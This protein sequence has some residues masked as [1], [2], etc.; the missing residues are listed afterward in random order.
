MSQEQTTL[1]DTI[2]TA[3][4]SVIPGEGVDATA[5]ADIT[6]PKTDA[7]EIKAEAPKSEAPREDRQR[8]PDGTFAPKE[9]APPQVKSAK[10]ETPPPP[11]VGAAPKR[12]TTWKKEQWENFD[13]LHAENP[14]LASY[15]LERE[16]Q[17]A[18]GVS[19]YK[20]EW[21]RAKPILDALTPFMPDLERHQIAPDRFVANLAQAHR[22]LALGSPQ[23]K[24]AMFAN[25]A[26]QYQIPL[27]QMFEQ[28]ADGQV[29]LRSIPTPQ[30]QG[31]TP[32]D[33]EQMVQK[34]F[35]EQSTTH[36][37]TSFQAARDA[38]GNPLYPHFEQVKETM[39]G[40][41]QAGLAEDLKGAYEAALRHPRHEELFSGVQRQ[42]RE[43]E[44]ARI[45]QEKAQQ[46]A[47][48]KRNAIST[49][50]ST[51]TGTAVANTGKKGLRAMLEENFDAVSA[52]RV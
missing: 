15:I 33:V 37:I 16:D 22:T 35:A 12:P 41:L 3:Y 14:T 2:E 50:T 28:G 42:Q 8:N 44:E 13:K 32:Q 20:S 27:N 25:L 38:S 46:A 39:A 31:L 9:A 34:K 7:V 43:A 23:E 19:T 26:Q 4:N 47:R 40:L 51:P 5:S 36:E 24:L 49:P 29:Y 21:D 11:A 17:Y 10:T 45:A 52:S 18:K 1:R 6:A 30:P 48:A